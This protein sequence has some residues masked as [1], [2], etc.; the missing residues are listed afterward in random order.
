MS[1]IKRFMARFL[2]YLL[3]STVIFFSM[4]W[5]TDADT[6]RDFPIP[7]GIVSDFTGSLGPDD[8]NEILKELD[9][10]YDN[11]GMQGH[12]VIT[13]STGEWYL[14]EYVKDYADYLQGRG[15]LDSTSWLLYISTAD[16]KFGIAVQD[17]SKP[18]FDSFVIR[19]LSLLVSENLEKKDVKAAILAVTDFVADLPAPQKVHEQRKVSPDMLIFGGI[20]VMVIALM[21]RLRRPKKVPVNTGR[22][23]GF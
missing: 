23:S 10:A 9:R 8:V 6:G 18:V 21:L 12:V 20:A 3:V 17:S 19:E 11:N 13:L 14:D 5:A 7:D 16:R 4:A 22:K 2:F 15:I 1:Y